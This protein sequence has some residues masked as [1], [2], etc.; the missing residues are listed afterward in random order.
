MRIVGTIIV[1]LIVGIIGLVL[2]LDPPPLRLQEETEFI[3]SVPAPKPPSALDPLQM[4]I[5]CDRKLEAYTG[6]NRWGRPQITFFDWLKRQSGIPPEPDYHLYGVKM[7]DTWTFKIDPA[8]RTVCYQKSVE[9][10]ITDPYCGPK[11]TFEN[12]DRIIA[13]E[14]AHYGWDD[15]VSTILFSKRN[16]TL[17]MTQ[18]N[19]L[20]KLGASIK[21]FQCH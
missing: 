19:N 4:G 17:V 5:A 11:I 8:I 3:L 1:V 14:D 9:V 16:F 20:E 18:I 2:V 7:S 10:G 6:F 15:A 12:E 21:Y 13:V